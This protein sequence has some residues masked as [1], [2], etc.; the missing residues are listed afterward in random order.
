MLKVHFTLKLMNRVR[1]FFNIYEKGCPLSLYIFHKETT[2][3]VAYPEKILFKHVHP[4]PQNNV[5]FEL[6]MRHFYQIIV[7]SLELEML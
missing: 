4:R 7:L 3:V 1:F 6:K 5:G 2:A